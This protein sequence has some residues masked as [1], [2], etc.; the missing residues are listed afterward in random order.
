MN[1]ELQREFS[2]EA[3]T[4]GARA[5]PERLVATLLK[6]SRFLVIPRHPNELKNSFG[7]RDL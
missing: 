1:I 6:M 2:S 3:E 4:D 5:E 7:T